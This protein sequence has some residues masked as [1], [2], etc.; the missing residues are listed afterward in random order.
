MAAGIFTDEEKVRLR[1]HLGYLNVQE[2]MTFVLGLPAG[3]QTQ[4]QIEGA[5]NRVLEAAMPQAR[6]HM[7]ILDQIESQMVEDLELLAI[8]SID[9]IKVRADEQA[10]LRDQY[11]YWRLGLANLLGI[12]PNPYDKRY[13]EAGINVSVQH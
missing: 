13:S 10:K 4:F 8:E 6:R 2:S 7:S 3:V 12:S 1:H 5:M 9:T 11:L